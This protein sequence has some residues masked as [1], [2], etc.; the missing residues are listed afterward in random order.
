MK[1]NGREMLEDEQLE[2]NEILNAVEPPIM[3][4]EDA[5]HAAYR[6]AAQVWLHH[7]ERVYNG[8]LRYRGS[9]K[10]G[11]NKLFALEC[12]IAAHGLW[13]LLSPARTMDDL[14]RKWNCTKA[15]VSKLVKQFQ[16]KNRLPP[17]PGQR[18]T[19][20]CENMRQARMKQLT[21]T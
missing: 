2:E 16:K 18:T 4:E 8:V 12:A 6:R 21:N 19:Q 10:F 20:A 13:H 5:E 17:A 14:A 11:C 3:E 9:R 1:H 7:Q 15:H